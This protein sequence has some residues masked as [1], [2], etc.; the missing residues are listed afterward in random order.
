[1]VIAECY[2]LLCFE[3]VTAAE[4][5]ASSGARSADSSA[6]TIDRNAMVSI[7]KHRIGVD[8]LL[9]LL[10]DVRRVGGVFA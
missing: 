7:I 5:A 6:D 10:R 3:P 4:R 9:G 1:L 8:V 2:N